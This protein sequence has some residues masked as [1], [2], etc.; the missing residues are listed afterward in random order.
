MKDERCEAIHGP[1]GERCLRGPHVGK[2]V[3][4][5]PVDWFTGGEDTVRSGKKSTK[6]SDGPVYLEFR[7]GPK[8]VPLGYFWGP[9]REKEG[10]AGKPAHFGLDEPE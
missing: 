2:H 5:G 10:L 6:Q 1:S 3:G 4:R 8:R 7:Y 9:A